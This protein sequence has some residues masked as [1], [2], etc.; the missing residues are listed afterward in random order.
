MSAR[1]LEKAFLAANQELRV[2]FQ[3]RFMDITKLED[4]TLRPNVT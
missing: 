4:V 2:T 3:G 1:K